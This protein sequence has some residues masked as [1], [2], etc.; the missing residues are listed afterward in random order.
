MPPIKITLARLIELFGKSVNSDLPDSV[1]ALAARLMTLTAHTLRIDQRTAA[2][3][4]Q[5]KVLSEQISTLTD[6]VQALAQPGA[7]SAAPAPAAAEAAPAP[8]P[9]ES[10]DA[11]DGED[12]TE[13]A[14]FARAQAEAEADVAAINSTLPPEPAPVAAVT[15]LPRS[16]KAGGA[17]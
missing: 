12:E 11:G 10:E 6:I 15:P 7:T 8:A 14:F 4:A 1:R 16:K 13:E 2:H 17:K 3:N 5:I 9:T